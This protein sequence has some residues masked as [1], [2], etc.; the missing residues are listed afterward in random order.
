MNL[1]QSAN[2]SPP[3]V[4]L[5]R[6]GLA[7]WQAETVNRYIEENLSSSIRITTLAHLVQLSLSH[8]FRAFR[9]TFSGTPRAYIEKWRIVRGQ[10]LMLKSDF[11]MAQI[12]LE[13]GMCDQA[14][15]C[16]TF[17]RVVGINPNA[18]RRQN[19]L[20]ARSRL[21]PMTGILHQPTP[22]LHESAAAIPNAVGRNAE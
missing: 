4:Y 15:F 19:L 9:L 18:W 1:Q 16:R 20:N 2:E 11:S 5:R 10:Q 3:Q 17:R 21:T 12:A 22:G 8:F 7:P 13:I 6:G 14:H